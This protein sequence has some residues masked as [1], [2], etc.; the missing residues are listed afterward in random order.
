MRRRGRRE[1][2]RVPPPS[3]PGRA[4]RRA[5]RRAG[6]GCPR[7]RPARHRRRWSRTGSRGSP[8]RTLRS[9][10]SA[11]RAGSAR[12]AP[13][14]GGTQARASRSARRPASA[15]R[16]RGLMPADPGVGVDR[17]V[18]RRDCP[19]GVVGGKQPWHQLEP[20]GLERLADPFER[21]LRGPTFEAGD[22]GLRGSEPCGEFRLGEP[23]STTSLAD[24]GASS[25][26]GSIAETLCTGRSLSRRRPRRVVS[27]RPSS[28]AS[29]AGA[30]RSRS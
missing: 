2:R 24:E 12:R 6:R 9:A 11:P 4:A 17:E 13:A 25:H 21:G 26:G 5:R 15:K 22:R 18:R 27:S 23:G 19:V 8:P 10:R 30:G 14:R 20:A 1:A 3:R 16:T 29:P 28:R 7:R